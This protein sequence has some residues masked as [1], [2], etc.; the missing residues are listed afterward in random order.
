MLDCSSTEDRD[1]QRLKEILE[2]NERLLE[3]NKKLKMRLYK[4]KKERDSLAKHFILEETSEAP[5]TLTLRAAS[6]LDNDDVETGMDLSPT[7]AATT[8][9]KSSSH[10]Y[11][12]MG[13]NDVVFK[14]EDPPTIERKVKIPL[15]KFDVPEV[16][17]D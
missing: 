13:I 10:K 1:L 4:A 3:Q 15:P 11:G 16:V 17:D 8:S 14:E 7:A 9:S 5:A 12:Y 2:A 6:P